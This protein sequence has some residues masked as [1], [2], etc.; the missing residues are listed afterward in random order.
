MP[1]PVTTQVPPPVSEQVIVAPAPASHGAARTSTTDL[2]A[3]YDL[4][5][6]GQF[7]NDLNPDPLL[8]AAGKPTPAAQTPPPARP[9]HSALVRRLAKELGVKD[10]D[11]DV[12]SPEEAE[13]LVAALHEQRQSTR[14]TNQIERTPTPAVA[15]PAPQPAAPQSHQEA[16]PA[17]E[18]FDLG[19]SEDEFDPALLAALKKLTGHFAAKVAELKQGLAG[20]TQ[21]EQRRQQQTVAEQID[22]GF[23]DLGEDLVGTLGKGGRADLRDGDPALD[24]RMAVLH[25]LQ[26]RPGTGTLRQQVAARAKELFGTAAAPAAPQP[27]PQ[28][29]P[30]PKRR[31]VQ[32]PVT[33]QFTGEFEEIDE[34]QQAR[35]DAWARAGLARP[36]SREHPP[37]PKGDRRA[38]KAV[39]AF[40]QSNGFGESRNGT[41]GDEEAD[42]PD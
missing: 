3:E 27:E 8:A 5:D 30:A 1:E 20:L 24:R 28:A 37:E 23:A 39:A 38:A 18:E 12:A 36:T 40:Q 4:D 34:G 6:D 25:S 15:Q 42:L 9:R 41:A 26:R 33:G 2:V 32:H 11:L 16:A 35:Q 14:L 17:P 21:V 31:P 13:R 19:L 22:A 10:E 29:P 7:D